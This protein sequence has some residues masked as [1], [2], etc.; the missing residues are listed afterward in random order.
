VRAA[1]FT[2]MRTAGSHEHWEHPSYRGTRRLVTI[3]AKY[4]DFDPSRIKT[5]M[6]QAG[7]SRDEFYCQTAHTARKINKQASPRT[8]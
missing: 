1:G 2:L 8:A 5:M 4:D 7:M 3:D 6:S